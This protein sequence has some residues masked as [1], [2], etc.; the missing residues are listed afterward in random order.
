MN[1]E[2]RFTRIPINLDATIKYDGGS[3]EGTVANISLK[4]VLIETKQDYTDKKFEKCQV[5]I[6]LPVGDTEM[7]FDSKLVHVSSM[8][9]GFEFISEDIDSFTHLRKLLEVHGLNLDSMTDEI[10]TLIEAHQKEMEKS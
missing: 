8:A 1:T 9:M 10:M 3:C 6:Q 5:H 2:R 4:G 7:I